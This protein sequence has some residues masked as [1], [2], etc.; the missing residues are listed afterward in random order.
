MET[1]LVPLDDRARWDALAAKAGHV[2]VQQGWAYGEVL[3]R[4]GARVE[5]LG[6]FEAGQCVGVVQLVG[7]RPLGGPFRLW[8]GLGGPL[9]LRSDDPHAGIAV[10][11]LLRRRYGWRRAG[12]LLLTPASGDAAMEARRLEAA[13]F[14]RAM[15]G[16]TTARLD[17]AAPL[18]DLQRCLVPAWRRELR[19]GEVALT[20][21]WS[22]PRAD[23]ATLDVLLEREAGERRRRGYA[24]LPAAVVREVARASGGLLA[25]ARRDGRLV[26]AML[27]LRHGRTAVYQTGWSDGDGRRGRAHHRA[28]WG[29]IERLQEAGVRWLD[30]GGLNLPAGIVRFKLGCGA[31]PVTFAGTFV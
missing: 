12:L 9:W 28:L 17:L 16:Y 29:T 25:S 27:F 30:L 2:Q 14:R 3:A 23:P 11:G 26:A 31:T 6:L 18:A 24:A 1:C 7:R 19:R 8:H 13:G 10:L 15:T 5:R 20:F 21:E 4:R 22:D